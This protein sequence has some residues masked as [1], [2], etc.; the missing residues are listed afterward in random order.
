MDIALFVTFVVMLFGGG[1]TTLRKG[2]IQAT[3]KFAVEGF[4][5][6]IIGVLLLLAIP[7]L[8]AAFF[9][10]NWFLGLFGIKPGFDSP[11]PMFI[12]LA[13]LLGCPLLAVIIGFATAKDGRSTEAR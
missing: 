12:G 2:R 11:L 7:M 5:A 10:G 8:L 1:V 3:R 4:P 9:F 13:P 6:R